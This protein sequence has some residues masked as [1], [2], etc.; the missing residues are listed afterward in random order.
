MKKAKKTTSSSAK[1]KAVREK[2]FRRVLIPLVSGKENDEGFITEACAEADELVL[3]LVVDTDAMP[4]GFGF[5]A[6]EIGHGNTLMEEVKVIADGHGVDCNDIVE[7]GDTQTK[8][9]HLIQ[10]KGI[11]NVFLIKQENEFFKKL[12][13]ALREETTAEV[14]IFKLPEKEEE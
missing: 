10:L 12:V 1:N 14:E 7:W 13:K 2:E 11:K 3:L 9:L 5:A 4:G 8:I 6:G